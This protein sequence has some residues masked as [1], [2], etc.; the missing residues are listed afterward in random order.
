MILTILKSI[1]IYVLIHAFLF[2]VVVDVR[3]PLASHVFVDAHV[4]SELSPGA[5][6]AE[7]R[8]Q[9]NRRPWSVQ[10]GAGAGRELCP[11]SP[12]R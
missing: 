1:L 12:G 7:P 3:R 9:Q 11:N 5:E 2:V 6:V 8:R 4:Y 10:P